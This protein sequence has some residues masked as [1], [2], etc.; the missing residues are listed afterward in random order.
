M[1]IHRDGDDANIRIFSILTNFQ[2]FYD[3]R[4]TPK[5]A[6]DV[7]YHRDCAVPLSFPFR[8]GSGERKAKGREGF[9]LLVVSARGT[10]A[11]LLFATLHNT[12]LHPKTSPPDKLT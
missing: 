4:V 7:S 2:H 6:L 9:M 10:T 3:I 1:V 11:L 5:W 12:C 8:G